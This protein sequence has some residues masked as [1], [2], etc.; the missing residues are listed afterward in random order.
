MPDNGWESPSGARCTTVGAATVPVPAASRRSG[1]GL[2]Q[3]GLSVAAVFE[4]D[5]VIDPAETRRWIVSSFP[6]RKVG[7]QP[8]KVRP[9]IDTW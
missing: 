6:A 7:P 2:P 4:I 8:Q 9:N 3:R 1:S 5:D